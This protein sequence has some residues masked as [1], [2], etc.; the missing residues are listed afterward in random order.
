[1]RMICR[2]T[3]MMIRRVNRMMI[4]RMPEKRKEM[5]YLS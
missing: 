2:V 5:K 3:R 4:R 1:M